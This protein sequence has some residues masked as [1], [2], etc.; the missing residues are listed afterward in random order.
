MLQELNKFSNWHVGTLNKKDP[1][2]KEWFV[3]FQATDLIAWA[4]RRLYEQ[5][6]AKKPLGPIAHMVHRLLPLKNLY[7]GQEQL[8]NYCLANSHVVPPRIPRWG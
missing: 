1:I 6:E 7:Y 2:T 8:M 5:A 3:P 4:I